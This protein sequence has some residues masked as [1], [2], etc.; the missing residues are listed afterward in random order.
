M[1]VVVVVVTVVVTVVVMKIMVVAVTVSCARTCIP[2]WASAASSGLTRAKTCTDDF[3]RPLMFRSSSRPCG[4][5]L[6]GGYKIARFGDN[7]MVPAGVGH[8]CSSSVASTGT[9][10]KEQ[11]RISCEQG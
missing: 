5:S 7:G 6:I 2:Q 10:Y 1:V 3:V 8:H 4:S 11:F 9:S